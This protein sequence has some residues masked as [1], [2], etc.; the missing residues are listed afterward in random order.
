MGKHEP[1][2][3]PTARNFAHIYTWNVF[4][5]KILTFSIS[6]NIWRYLLCKYAR[7]VYFEQRHILCKHPFNK[8][9]DK[10]ESHRSSCEQHIT[11]F[12]W[13][14]H[15]QF[16]YWN[17]FPQCYI[18]VYIIYP[19]HCASHR[20]CMIAS[21][22]LIDTRSFHARRC[23][24]HVPLN[25]GQFLVVS[26]IEPENK[27]FKF[28]IWYCWNWISVLFSAQH[29]DAV[30]G[31]SPNLLFDDPFNS[32]PFDVLLWYFHPLCWREIR[33]G[34]CSPHSRHFVWFIVGWSFVE[35]WTKSSRRLL[36]TQPLGLAS[37]NFL[38][39]Y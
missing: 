4:T 24:P 14:K 34:Y 36:L 3:G 9:L 17:Y 23:L 12:Q 19:T 15:V 21:Q 2:S 26:I 27:C 35:A 10:A 1:G 5:C 33:W 22:S 20:I 13:G 32:S 28:Y 8:G 11:F 37:L 38:E 18:K 29:G 31:G 39:F 16:C 7:F 30:I 25:K 6:Q